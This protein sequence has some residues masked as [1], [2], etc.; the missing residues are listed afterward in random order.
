MA[1]ILSNVFLT[2]IRERQLHCCSIRLKGEFQHK[3]HRNLGT[4]TDYSPFMSAN[5]SALRANPT[6]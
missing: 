1:L 5:K 4:I 6:K 3:I 2:R